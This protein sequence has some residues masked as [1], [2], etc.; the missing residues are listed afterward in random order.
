M[1][2]QPD[3]PSVEITTFRVDGEYADHRH[4]ERVTFTGISPAGF[5]R[6]DFTINAM[7]LGENGLIDL[8][9]GFSDLQNK[10]IRCV[11]ESGSPV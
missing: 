6:R 10:V 5:G 8:F 3:A 2:P 7:A 11:G 9:H 1:F 4:P